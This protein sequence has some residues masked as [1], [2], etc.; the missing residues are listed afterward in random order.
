MAFS[1]NAQTIEGTWHGVLK[2]QKLELRIVFNI[3]KRD[4]SYF[5]TMDS[6]DQG[7]MGIPVQLI[8]FQNSVLKISIPKA[9]IEYSGLHMDE[10]IIGTFHQSGQSIPMNLSKKASEGPK[11]PM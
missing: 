3:E 8:S 10:R 5:A 7:A 6:P 1:G 11:R 4:T 2:V 9:S